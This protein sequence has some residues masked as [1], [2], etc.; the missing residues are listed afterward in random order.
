MRSVL[1][2]FGVFWGIFML[3]V[4]SGA[5]YGLQNGVL[6]RREGFAENSAYFF[7]NV[8]TEAYKGFRKGRYWNLRNNDMDMLA[9][10]V[11]RNKIHLP[12]SIRRPQ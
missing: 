9:A 5:G 2:A 4:M 11:P 7:S 8:T 3:V 10:Q 1:T 12:H 6:A